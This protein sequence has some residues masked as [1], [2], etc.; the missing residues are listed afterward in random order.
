MTTYSGQYCYEIG[1]T[2]QFDAVGSSIYYEYPAPSSSTENS[3]STSNDELVLAFQTQN[4]NGVL[5]AVQCAVEDDYFTV[6]LV[7]EYLYLRWL[8]D[9]YF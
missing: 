3:P 7:M 6:F 4:S 9:L 2:Y 8:S 1:T 5:L